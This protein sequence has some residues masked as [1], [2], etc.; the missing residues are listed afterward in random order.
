MCA[1]GS[2]EAL[3]GYNGCKTAKDIDIEIGGDK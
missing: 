3:V 2:D 1:N